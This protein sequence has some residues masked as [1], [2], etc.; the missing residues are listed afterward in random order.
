MPRQRKGDNARTAVAIIATAVL[1]V[2]LVG[3]AIAVY[4]ITGPSGISPD[5]DTG[6][7]FR[8][9]VAPVTD[10]IRFTDANEF[11]EWMI[12]AD[13]KAQQSGYNKVMMMRDMGGVMDMG[14]GMAETAAPPTLGMDE[15]VTS[16]RYSETNVQ[17]AGIDEP[18]IIK[19][20]G[21]EIY[22]SQ[23]SGFYRPM[24]EV[25]ERE[26]GFAPPG[27]YEM[28]GVKA[29]TA[30]PPEDMGID[31]ELPRS[32][33]LLLHQDVLGVLSHDGIYA[34]DV[35]DPENPTETWNYTYE[36][37][38]YA[39]AS[40][41]KDGKLFLVLSG[42]INRNIPCPYVPVMR[43]GEDVSIACGDVWHPVI[44]AP[45]DVTYTILKVDMATGATERQVSFVGSRS[46]SQ[47]YMSADNLY[48]TTLYPPDTFTFMSG[49]LGANG[50]LVPGWL[51]KKIKR[52]AG[53][54]ISEEAKL[55]ELRKM[56]EQWSS[57]MD[58]DEMLRVSNEL[59]NRADDWFG[60]H[61]REMQST[62][63]VRVS[64][65]TLSLEASGEVPGRLLNQFS[66]DEYDGH[67]RVATTIPEASGMF[68]QFGF[69]GVGESE[70][71]VYV[72]DMALQQVGA[73]L[74]MGVD[75]RIYSVRF[76]ADQGYVVT[77]RQI[78]P[79][80]VLDMSVPSN[81]RVTGELKIPGYS[82]YL[83]PMPD[84]NILGIGKEDNRVK[85]SLFDVSDPTDP[86]E[87]A[88]YALNEYW[89]DIL[90][91]HHAFLLDP[92]HEIFFLPGSKGGYVFS[93]EGGDI[94]LLKA[95]SDVRARRALYIDDYLY[96][97][98]DDE[99]VVLEMDE[100][101]RVEELGLR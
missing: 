46:T 100:W 94:E 77:F 24:M 3:G 69:G 66:L 4:L 29:I 37:N 83:H 25:M 84:G 95:V 43:D 2:A 88:K 35:S 16:E 18:D 89:S 7:E 76:I 8:P 14:L 32:G 12:V 39:V 23:Q 92:K 48:V 40:R 101:E 49:F 38:N 34:Y 10:F 53:Y 68:W 80:Y 31:A 78:D 20:D 96:V 1:T 54:D 98:G 27:S 11:N 17:V 61:S 75:E 72:L 73:A 65:D 22:Y 52:V 91:T 26:V 19:T 67:L 6:P 51:I 21:Q 56:L 59:E 45:S 15:S 30:F 41:L 82:S 60:M 62:G 85:L 97:V 55:V 33:D 64:S 70:N 36:K 87:V 90:S 9:V 57:G 28:P 93:Y 63:I 50:D 58:E 5:G 42:G 44:P 81:P 74:G 13:E 99:L 71:D 79:F 47:V 86:T